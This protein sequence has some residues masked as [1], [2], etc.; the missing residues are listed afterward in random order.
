MVI[1]GAYPATFLNTCIK[2][3]VDTPVGPPIPFNQPQKFKLWISDITNLKKIEYRLT[4]PQ[5]ERMPPT[6]D[7][8]DNELNEIH[9]YLQLVKP[10]Q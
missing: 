3:H 2:C 7:L 4:A 5:I 1:R 10:H 8:D 9:R 6:R